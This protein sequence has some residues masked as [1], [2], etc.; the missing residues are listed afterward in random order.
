MF[1]RKAKLF[2]MMF[3]LIW[4]DFFPNFFNEQLLQIL[5]RKLK[6]NCTECLLNNTLKKET[7]YGKMIEVGIVLLLMIEILEHKVS[8]MALWL[9]RTIFISLIFLLFQGIPLPLTS[10]LPQRACQLVKLIRGKKAHEA[11]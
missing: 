10:A 5:L 3:H 2:L 6:N 1:N 4:N 9:R 8:L 11:N 7:M